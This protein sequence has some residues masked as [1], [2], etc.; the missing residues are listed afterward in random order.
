[1]LTNALKIVLIIGIAVG[2][3]SV[4]HYYMIYLP[5]M[6]REL[7]AQRDRERADEAE[8]RSKEA[9]DKANSLQSCL[10]LAEQDYIDVQNSLCQQTGRQPLCQEFIGSPKDIEFTKILNDKKQLC[11]NTYK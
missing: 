3:Y 4:Y 9:S 6:D 7:A 10:N 8:A 5:N 11:I 2:S 1:M